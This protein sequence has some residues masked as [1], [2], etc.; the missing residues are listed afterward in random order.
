MSPVEV[1]L[2]GSG[3]AFGS[4][5]RM[6]SCI[7]VHRT[8]GCFLIDCGASCL[9]G[10]NRFGV[11]PNDIGTILVSHLHGDHFGGLPFLLLG[12]RLLF[13]RTEPLRI[14]GPP[15]MR[16]RLPE[17]MEVLFP[18]SSRMGGAFPLEILEYGDRSPLQTGGLTVVPFANRHPR[19]D[20]SHSLRIECDGRVIGFSG[21]TEWTDSLQAAAEGA[22]LF[23]AEAYFREKRVK[24]HLDY[25]TLAARFEQTGAKRL[26]L[27][28]MSPDMLAR[29]DVPVGERA[30]DGMRIPL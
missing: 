12:S 4:G 23:I 18:G 17:A 26:V 15:G 2:L 7:L 29:R 1:L 20:C 14:V 11:N 5:G 9:I 3:D 22:D 21:D 25:V 30:W 6:Q 16:E 10:M 8:G 28:H 24:G 19:V 13:K 27:V